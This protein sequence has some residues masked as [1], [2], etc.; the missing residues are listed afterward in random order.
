MKLTKERKTLLLSVMVVGIAATMLG[1]GTLAYFSSTVEIEDNLFTAGTIELEVDTTWLTDANFTA[2]LTELKPCMKGWGNV[3]LENTGTNP[4]DV[5]LMIKDVSTGDGVETT[6]EGEETA[7]NNIDGVIRYDLNV[8][9]SPKIVDANDYTIS[10]GTHGL[11][12]SGVKDNYIY[13]GEIPFEGSLTVDQSFTMD[14]DTTN[15]AQGDTMEFTVEFFAQQSEGNPP[16][17]TPELSGFEK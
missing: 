13:L 10:D 4:M 14:C 8:D 16:S 15:W 17:P 11:T 12:T 5:W 9:G 1:A 6:P 2:N 3:T 7:A